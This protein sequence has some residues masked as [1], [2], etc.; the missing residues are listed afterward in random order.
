MQ[1]T[2]SWPGEKLWVMQPDMKTVEYARELV[3]RA[4]D[5]ELLTAEDMKMPK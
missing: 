4:L 3:Q 5:G 1:E 2:Y